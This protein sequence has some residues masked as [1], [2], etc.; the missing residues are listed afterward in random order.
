[1]GGLGGNIGP[2]L[3]SV[4]NRFNRAGIL[5]EIIHPSWS[6]SDQY[7]SYMVT[8][9]NGDSHTGQIVKRRDTVEIYTQNVDQPPIIVSRDEVTSIEK[10]E[11]SQMPPGLINTLNPDELRDLMAYLMTAG[12]PEADVYQNEDEDSDSDNDEELEETE[13]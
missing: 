12:N 8:M 2:D 1:M 10:A 9:N 5:E 11:I 3:S 7:S 13:D 4:S 6:I